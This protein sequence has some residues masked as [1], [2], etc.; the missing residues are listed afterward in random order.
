M[1]SPLT[2]QQALANF[3]LLTELSERNSYE[4]YRSAVNEIVDTVHEHG[5]LGDDAHPLPTDALAASLREAIAFIQASFGEP[6][7]DADETIT[8]STDEGPEVTFHIAK[9]KAALRLHKLR[10]ILAQFTDIEPHATHLCDLDDSEFT[11]GGRI[12]DIYKANGHDEVGRVC[13]NHANAWPLTVAEW[14]AS[15]A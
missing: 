9:A 14:A 5:I 3:T 7:D 2:P 15:I 10:S 8:T 13:V 12:T 6:F 4:D 11:F 1:K